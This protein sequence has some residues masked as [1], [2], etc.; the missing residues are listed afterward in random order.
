MKRS[1]EEISYDLCPECG[2]MVLKG[3]NFCSNC[4]ER[5]SLKNIKIV[6]RG[7]TISKEEDF[8]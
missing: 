4:G 2:S 3:D 5:L 6:T 8:K 7:N 1:I